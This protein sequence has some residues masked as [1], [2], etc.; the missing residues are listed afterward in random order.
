MF[1]KSI[2]MTLKFLMGMI[3]M[4]WQNINLHEHIECVSMYYIRYDAMFI[5]AECI[6]G[7]M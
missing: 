5:K 1:A 4:E 6:L 7:G 3:I 2:D